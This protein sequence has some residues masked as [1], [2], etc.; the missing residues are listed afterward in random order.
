M[1]MVGG[2][3]SIS[4]RSC[5]LVTIEMHSGI[6]YG[7]YLICYSSRRLSSYSD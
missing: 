1:D 3:T 2:K 5:F 7:Y 6:N 4:R